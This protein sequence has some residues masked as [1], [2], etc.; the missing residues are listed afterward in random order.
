MIPTAAFWS[1]TNLV[2]TE[3]LPT[4]HC[5]QLFQDQYWCLNLLFSTT[6]ETL[7][8]SK[9]ICLLLV[10]RGSLFCLQFFK[11]LIKGRLSLLIRT[12]D[13]DAAP[14]K[15]F[16]TPT[17]MVLEIWWETYLNWCLMQSSGH[18]LWA[19]GCAD[20]SITV[21]LLPDV[22]KAC[23]TCRVLL[24]PSILV[25]LVLNADKRLLWGPKNDV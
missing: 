4:E 11:L 21:L 3:M 24:Y 16:A 17:L 2:F 6:Q 5:L 9:H 20:D 10:L 19:C 8:L 1:A 22:N 18:S 25:V 23:S 13:S 14:T 12:A 15:D 7:N